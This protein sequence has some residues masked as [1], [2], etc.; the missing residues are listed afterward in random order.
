MD[1]QS[2][3]L[4]KRMKFFFKYNL[5]FRMRHEEESHYDEVSRSSSDNYRNCR[6][7]K[8]PVKKLIK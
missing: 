1:F 2:I 4:N 5:S 7:D 6:N 3:V 8:N